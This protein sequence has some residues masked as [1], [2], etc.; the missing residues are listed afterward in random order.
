MVDSRYPQRSAA[1]RPE[2]KRWFAPFLF[3]RH[4][5]FALI[6]AFAFVVII[7]WQRTAV[8]RVWAAGAPPVPLPIPRLRS[9]VFNLSDF[10]AVGDGYTMNTKAF[11]RAILEIQRRGG[12]QLNVEA[13]RWLTAPFNLTSHMTL[14]LAQNAVILGIDVRC[15]VPF[16]F[17]ILL[18]IKLDCILT[19]LLLIK[20]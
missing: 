4:T 9:L 12:G 15:L 7:A 13:G 6:W 18:L 10:G 14:F 5:V 8:D 2:T 17:D 20:Q 3:S 16:R 1:F 19:F 11:E